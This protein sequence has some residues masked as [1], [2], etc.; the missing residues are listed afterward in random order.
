MQSISTLSWKPSVVKAM[1]RFLLLAGLF[2]VFID[3]S[4]AANKERDPRIIDIETVTERAYT[5]PK[6]D[7]DGAKKIKRQ[8]NKTQMIVKA[9][10]RRL[11]VQKIAMKRRIKAGLD[12]VGKALKQKGA[13]N[14]NDKGKIIKIDAPKVREVKNRFMDFT[15]M[16]FGSEDDKPCMQAAEFGMRAGAIANKIRGRKSKR[17]MQKGDMTMQSRLG[18]D[19]HNRLPFSFH[20]NRSWIED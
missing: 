16:L 14:V 9:N 8:T 3:S 10:Q 11:Q 12:L 5:K 15:K 13:I 17:R 4:F 1:L 18:A 6:D 2:L 20:G 19:N 7:H